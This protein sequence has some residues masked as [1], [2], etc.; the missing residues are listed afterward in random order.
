MS[1]RI[2]SKIHDDK[3]WRGLSGDVAQDS[4]PCQ[5]RCWCSSAWFF[6]CWFLHAG[7]SAGLSPGS[8]ERKT[9]P[10]RGVCVCVCVCVRS[11]VGRRTPS[12]CTSWSAWNRTRSTMLWFVSK[13]CE[14]CPK[15]SIQKARR[16]NPM[17]SKLV[18]NPLAIR[19]K[20]SGCSKMCRQMSASSDAACEFVQFFAVASQHGDL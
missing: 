4:R 9:E 20:K 5:P 17:M 1:H 16:R 6:C 11:H 19:K 7:Q 2:R 15:A 10:M 14:S 8:S 18:R 12:T 3:C 13:S